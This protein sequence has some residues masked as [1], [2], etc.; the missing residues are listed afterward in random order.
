MTDRD[1][2]ITPLLVVLYLAGLAVAMAAIPGCGSGALRHHAT[3]ALVAMT[4]ESAA[5]DIYLAHLDATLGECTDDACV[6]RVTEEHAPAEAALEI[7][8]V[9][10]T[11][12]AD[13]IRIAQAADESGDVMSALISAALRLV[14]SWSEVVA[15]LARVG[16]VVPALP[17][18]VQ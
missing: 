18:G 8:R 14:R 9:A 10:I 6:A 13:A 1:L 7:A 2:S 17:G 4:A 3:T 5:Q 11:S 12:Y 16:V 15:A